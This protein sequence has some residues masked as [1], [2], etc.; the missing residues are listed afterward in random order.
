MK[1]L[2][3]QLFEEKAYGIIYLKGGAGNE[4]AAAPG[5]S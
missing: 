3:P 5:D 4:K 2:N 1:K